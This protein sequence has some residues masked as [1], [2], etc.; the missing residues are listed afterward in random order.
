MPPLLSGE[1]RQNYQLLTV[2]R[3]RLKFQ[4]PP[5]QSFN[6]LNRYLEDVLI[7]PHETKHFDV[8]VVWASQ[9]LSNYFQK[10]LFQQEAEYKKLSKNTKAY[11][12]NLRSLEEAKKELETRMQQLEEE[13]KELLKKIETYKEKFRS[14]EET[15][16]RIIAEALLD[17]FNV[18]ILAILSDDGT[19][20]IKVSELRNRISPV[21]EKFNIEFDE[22]SFIF[23][24][25]NLAKAG[26]LDVI[27]EEK[28]VKASPLSRFVLDRLSSPK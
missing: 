12:Q 9:E 20:K 16:K 11:E 1:E 28:K 24:M 23:K 6:V 10:M 26:L 17:N 22:E 7:L 25:M 8:G 19:P 5:E 2:R 4:K 21:L 27:E 13:N 15:K 3:E 18:A 14:L